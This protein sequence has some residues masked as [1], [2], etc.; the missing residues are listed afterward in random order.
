MSTIRRA[1]SAARIKPA[2]LTSAEQIQYKGFLR[3]G[4]T[5]IAVC[6]LAGEGVPLK[7]IVR[8]TGCSRQTVRRILRGER[9]D[10][11]RVRESSFEAW[12]PRLEREWVSGCHSEAELWRRL[13]NEGFG[14]NLRVVSEWASQRRR[15]EAAPHARPRVCPSVRRLAAMLTS[16]HGHLS[17]E[18][19]VT[20]APWSGPPFPPL[21]G[22]ARSA[23]GHAP[24]APRRL[25]CRTRLTGALPL[26]SISFAQRALFWACRGR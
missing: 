4:K 10:V 2:L 12:L 17:R 6:A 9:E 26:I 11:F 18:Q 15:A 7:Q 21:P 5:N 23:P 22:L 14:G 19:A 24:T 25:P 3:R 20:L 8:Q 1:L 16:G 13:R